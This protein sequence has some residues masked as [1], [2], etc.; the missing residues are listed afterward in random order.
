MKCKL[1]KSSAFGL[2]FL[3]SILVFLITC[4]SAAFHGVTPYW[5]ESLGFF[6]LTYICIDEFSKR[7]LDLNPWMIGF[8]IILGQIVFQGAVRATDFRASLGSLMIVVSCIIAII[9]AVFC[10]K[11][12]RPYTFIL[13][14]V[15]L[16][17][18]NTFVTEMWSDYFFSLHQ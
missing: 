15:V 10:Y 1:T 17:F 16:A 13:S 3:F 8:A 11:D 12:N 6:L 2:S 7:I 9:L 5:I 18:F 4:W 14:Y